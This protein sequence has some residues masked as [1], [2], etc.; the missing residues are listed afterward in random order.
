MKVVTKKKTGVVKVTLINNHVG[1]TEEVGGLNLT[2][3]ERAEIADKLSQNIPYQVI[4]DEIRTSKR[5]ELHRIHLTTRQDIANV[6]STF[7]L[8]KGERGFLHTNDNKIQKIRE[9]VDEI[10]EY[11]QTDE[12]ADI[13]WNAL[14]PVIPT[15]K[16]ASSTED[17][18]FV[19]ASGQ[20]KKVNVLQKMSP[21]ENFYSTKARRA[22][23]QN[24][25]LTPTDEEKRATAAALLMTN[26]NES[27]KM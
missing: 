8:G 7:K 26:F 27:Q 6:Q 25:L 19:P 11:L 15:I 22:K 17:S 14:L 5:S 3:V 10:L 16:A 24:A 1:H 13:L 9:K 2:K 12:Q 4:L 23:P 18:N 20:V 21:Q